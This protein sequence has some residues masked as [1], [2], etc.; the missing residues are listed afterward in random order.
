MNIKNVNLRVAIS[1]KCN[2]NC[3]Y[4]S[5]IN[6]NGDYL[7]AQMEDFRR[8]SI[9]NGSISKNVLIEILS[10]FKKKGVIGVSLTGG[11]PLL[12]PEF[13]SIVKNIS[14]LGFLRIETTTNGLLLTDYLNKNGKLPKELTLLKISIDTFN[15]KIFKTITRGGSL[16]KLING[17]KKL[18]KT[19]KDLKIRANTVLMKSNLSNFP[20][21][22]DNCRK[23]GI[24]EVT[25]LDLVYFKNKNQKQD[26]IFF[27]KEYINFKEFNNFISKKLSQK[28][29]KFQRYGHVLTLDDGFKIIFKDSNTSYRNPL[30]DKCSVY[31][32]EGV[33]TVRIATDGNITTCPDYEGQLLNIDGKSELLSGNLPKTIDSLIKFIKDSKQEESFKKYLKKHK[34][35]NNKLLSE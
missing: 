20:S 4:C 8:T 22:I 7:P 14:N 10:N 18:K 16:Q 32:Q 11:E 24:N 3:I 19:N 23:Y 1:S 31:C 25:V 9:K 35:K 33:Y 13:A 30:C 26:K 15:P 12:N 29:K 28:F 34:I 27:E 2:L 6:K 21:Y 17:I 5:K